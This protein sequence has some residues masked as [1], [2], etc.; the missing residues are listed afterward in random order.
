[1]R[2]SK[3]YLIVASMI[4]TLTACSPPGGKQAEL[5]KLERQRDALD[6]KIKAL[7][8][9]LD[10]AQGMPKPEAPGA[11]VE[12]AVVQFGLFQ[13]FIQVQGQV[14]S[15]NNVFVPPQSPGI[16]K[17]IHVRPGDRVGKG[18]LL[19]ELDGSILESGIAELENGLALA[20]TIFE[21]QQRL[22]DKKIGSEIEYLQAKNGK[23]SLEKKL[24]TLQEQYKMTKIYSP[25][26][27]TVDEVLLKE[28][29]MAAAG[30]GAV[31]VVQ[32]SNLK[33][34][35]DL[36]EVYIS[37]IRKN[38]PVLVSMPAVGKD[39][40][41]KISAVS[42]VIDPDNRT[43]QIEIKIPRSVEGV[44]P[45]M[46]AVL[47]INDYSNQ[48]AAVVPSNII[49]ETEKDRFLFVAE[50]ENG[51]WYARKRTVQIGESYGNNSEILSGLEEGERVVTIGYQALADGQKLT[52]IAADSE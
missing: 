26:S 52:V 39:M 24:K 25:L 6:A 36:S 21:R 40:E 51:T 8:T 13:H 23:E 35:V 45:N 43:F 49:Q 14:E 5:G 47:K 44:K 9:E 37:Q 34:K 16:V 41:L 46:L 28:G 32:L 50:E 1:M 11:N 38:D 15:D 10:A 30:F 48:K 18:Q 17:K 42:Q 12:I 29:E 2:I 3:T 33:L 19:V 7:K 20:R 4:L 31:R 22:W 27:G